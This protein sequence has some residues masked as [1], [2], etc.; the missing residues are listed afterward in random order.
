MRFSPG[1]C[2]LWVP[3]QRHVF[4]RNAELMPRR[5]RVKQPVVVG[6]HWGK[7]RR[8]EPKKHSIRRGAAAVR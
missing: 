6:P 3:N 2:R 8:M 1:L 5:S 7:Q 4:S